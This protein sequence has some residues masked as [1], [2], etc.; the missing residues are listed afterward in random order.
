MCCQPRDEVPDPPWHTQGHGTTTTALASAL[1]AA[2]TADLS[3]PM[4]TVAVDRPTHAP[5]HPLPADPIALAH[6]PSRPMYL[7]PARGT[8]C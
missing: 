2:A 8:T 7:P 1:A 4:A 3:T 6:L 5:R